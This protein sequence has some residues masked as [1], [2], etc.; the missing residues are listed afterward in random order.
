MPDPPGAGVGGRGGGVRES[1][2]KGRRGA[3]KQEAP[4]LR[5]S[6]LPTSPFSLPFMKGHGPYL[7]LHGVLVDGH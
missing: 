3:S 5:S 1:G 6:P 2:W 4:L 7:M